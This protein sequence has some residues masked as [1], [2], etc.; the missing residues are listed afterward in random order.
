MLT[1]NAQ[2]F[3]AR[4]RLADLDLEDRDLDLERLIN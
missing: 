2:H 4:R 1:T 3:Y